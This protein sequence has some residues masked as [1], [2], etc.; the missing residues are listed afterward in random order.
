MFRSARIKLT[1]SYVLIIMTITLSLST[2]I[3]TGVD[4]FTQRA[5]EM[6]QR[7]VE[8]RLNEFRG[9]YDEV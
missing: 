2:V 8:T 6:H 1:I 7:K 3:Y 9:L 5:L 4:K